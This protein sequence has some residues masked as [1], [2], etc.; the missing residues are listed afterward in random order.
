MIT[1]SNFNKIRIY[2]FKCSPSV[3]LYQKTKFISRSRLIKDCLN[4]SFF[5]KRMSKYNK[6]FGDNKLI[7]KQRRIKNKQR[8]IKND[9][10]CDYS[11]IEIK[12]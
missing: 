2:G 9:G 6:L 5:K 1:K 7:N 11:K 4:E 3:S 12:S 8:S 10:I